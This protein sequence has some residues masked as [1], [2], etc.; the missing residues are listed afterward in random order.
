VEDAVRTCELEDAQR[1]GVA[2]AAACGHP[3]AMDAMLRVTV[4]PERAATAGLWRQIEE[5]RRVY[6]D[7]LRG[8]G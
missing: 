1:L 5:A 2:V 3:A 6:H 7:R 4:G 8:R